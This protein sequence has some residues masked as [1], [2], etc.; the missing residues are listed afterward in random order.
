MK[1]LM[2]IFVTYLAISG[3]LLIVPFF[4]LFVSLPAFFVDS[5]LSKLGFGENVSMFAALATVFIF[6]TLFGKIYA[7]VRFKQMER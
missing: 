1:A 2:G 7:A 4:L 3:L 6:I 5:L